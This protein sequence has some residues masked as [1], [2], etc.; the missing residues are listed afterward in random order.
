[1]PIY[2]FCCTQ[3][4]TVFERIKSM[5]ESADGDTCPCGSPAKRI[6]SNFRTEE[7]FTPFYHEGLD[8]VVTS[9]RDMQK[10]MARQKVVPVMES[11]K[12]RNAMAEKMA[13]VM[14]KNKNPDF[15][16]KADRFLKSVH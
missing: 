6:I 1:M 2:E 8:K 13:K 15:L 9:R 14:Q 11:R 12:S 10:E 7:S 4:H 16:K 3:C 5:S